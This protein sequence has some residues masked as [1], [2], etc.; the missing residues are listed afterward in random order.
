MSLAAG[1]ALFKPTLGY[2]SKM[3]GYTLVLASYKHFNWV[4]RHFGP[5]SNSPSF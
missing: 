1:L 4:D 3:L 5:D 2:I